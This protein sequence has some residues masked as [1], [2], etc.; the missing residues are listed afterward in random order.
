MGFY[1][2]EASCLRDLS[3]EKIDHWIERRRIWRQVT[4]QRWMNGKQKHGTILGARIKDIT[5]EMVTNLHAVA[6]ILLGTTYEHKLVVSLDQCYVYTNH[7]ELFEQLQAFE[8]AKWPSFVQA[9]VVRDQNTVSLKNPKHQ[10]RTYFRSTRLT[11]Q[12]KDYLMDFLY[13][14]REH[15]RVSPALQRWIDQPFDRTQDYFFVD[16][17]SQTWTT[18]LALIHPGLIKKTLNIC[19]AK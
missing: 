12:Q 14:Q 16:H 11:A 19:A 17:N 7:K 8:G 10:F 3:H 6:E 5:D 18:M 13:N 1:L 4:Q 9:H 15:V 2:D